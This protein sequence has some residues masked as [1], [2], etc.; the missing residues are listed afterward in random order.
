MGNL[1]G[2][3]N[4]KWGVSY[5]E[6]IGHYLGERNADQKATSEGPEENLVISEDSNELK[7]IKKPLNFIKHPNMH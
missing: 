7:E 1:Q 3:Q 2:E 5:F 4:I 6:F